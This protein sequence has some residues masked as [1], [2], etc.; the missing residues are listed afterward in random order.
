MAHHHQTKADIYGLRSVAT[1]ELLKGVAAVTAGILLAMHPHAS[2]GHIAERI[3]HAV[4][5]RR[6]SIIAIELIS[7]AR[8]INIEHLQMVLLFVGIYA[9]FRLVEAWG[10][11]HAR[12]WAE[13]FGILNGALYLPIEVIELHRHFTDLKLAVLLI[14]IIVVAYLGWE[15]RKTRLQKSGNRSSGAAQASR[16]KTAT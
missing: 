5:I 4:H 14:N 2:F 3:L 12:E 6:S 9:L 8:K 13:W 7:W 16:Q 1:L 11:W 10:L 15:L